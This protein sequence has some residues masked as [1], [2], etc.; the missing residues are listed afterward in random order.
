MQGLTSH[1]VFGLNTVLILLISVSQL[2]SQN[3]QPTSRGPPPSKRR[4]VRGGANVVAPGMP[5][6][7]KPTFDQE[8]EAMASLYVLGNHV[9]R[10]YTTAEEYGKRGRQH[11]L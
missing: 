6:A 1:V 4:R 8:A 2:V 9:V 5:T 10:Q 7:L 11:S 3:R